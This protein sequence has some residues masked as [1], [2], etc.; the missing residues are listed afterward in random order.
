[1]PYLLLK[2]M[3]TLKVPITSLISGLSICYRN[4]NSLTAHNFS[5]VNLLEAYNSVHSFH[6]VCLSETFLDSTIQLHHPDL[7]MND[8]ILVRTCHLSNVKKGGV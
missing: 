1:M 7:L 6:I 2:K 5:K 3:V 8:Y 4:L